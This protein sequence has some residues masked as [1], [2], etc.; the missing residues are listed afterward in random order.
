M[1]AILKYLSAV[2]PLSLSLFIVYR[3][4][5]L[6]MNIPHLCTGFLYNFPVLPSLSSP[7]FD[8]LFLLASEYGETEV[9]NSDN[10]AQSKY[11]FK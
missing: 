6:A 10:V 8:L 9:E 7:L 5:N 4:C 1:V 3:I 11:Q 2:S